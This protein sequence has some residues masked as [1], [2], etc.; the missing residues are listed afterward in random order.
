MNRAQKAMDVTRVPR[1]L[2]QPVKFRPTVNW[3]KRHAKGPAKANAMAARHAVTAT[4]VN[5]TARVETD[6]ATVADTR[7][8]NHHA[9]PRVNPISRVTNAPTVA[10]AMTTKTAT[11]V[12]PDPMLTWG[13]CA[14][15]NPG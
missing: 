7:A 13:A 10:L 14:S 6:Q 4:A 3:R 2:S 1:K 11:N 15:V 12:N 9:R 8:H 5:A